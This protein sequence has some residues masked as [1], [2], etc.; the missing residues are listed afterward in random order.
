MLLNVYGQPYSKPLPVY[1]MKYGTQGLRVWHVDVPYEGRGTPEN[2]FWFSDLGK[3]YL[4]A[5]VDIKGKRHVRDFQSGDHWSP[6]P[7]V[8]SEMLQDSP[9]A[10][11]GA[12]TRLLSST[13]EA[14]C[15]PYKKLDAMHTTAQ[16]LLYE[17][18]LYSCGETGWYLDYSDPEDYTG[19]MK[20]FLMCYSLGEET[21]WIWTYGLTKPEELYPLSKTPPYA[22][23]ARMIA[24]T[25][26]PA[27]ALRTLG[28]LYRAFASFSTQ[29]NPGFVLNY[30]ARVP[31]ACSES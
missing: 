28:G 23:E 27:V 2:G 17:E 7:K 11:H 10:Y 19:S 9:E 24:K 14:P 30:M 5:S 18:P 31:F 1:H 25:S 16:W 13:L 3:G 4:R 8:L 15:A 12:W 21:Q 20:A 29:F 26:D 6:W 22:Y